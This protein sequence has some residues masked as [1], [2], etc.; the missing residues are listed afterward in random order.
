MPRFLKNARNAPLG[1]PQT[2]HG[3]AGAVA[4]RGDPQKLSCGTAQS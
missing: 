2:P 1:T 3:E 4:G